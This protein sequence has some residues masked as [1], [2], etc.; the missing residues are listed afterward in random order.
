MPTCWDEPLATL[1][2]QAEDWAGVWSIAYTVGRGLQRLASVEGWDEDLRLTYAGLD[3]ALAVSE[4]D[5]ADPTGTAQALDIDLGPGRPARD[6]AIG[7]LC[8]LIN[9]AVVLIGSLTSG[10]RSNARQVQAGMRAWVLL[11]R[12]QETLAGRGS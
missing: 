8:D 3:V 10:G 5:W 4:L 1:T 2:A 12:A 9:D 11:F 7:R 6:E